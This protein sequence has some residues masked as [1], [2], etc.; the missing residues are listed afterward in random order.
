MAEQQRF[1][2]GDYWL[3]K[4]HG[5]EQWCR[6]WFDPRARQTRRTSLG[7]TDLREAQLKLAEWVTLAGAQES[8]SEVALVMKGLEALEEELLECRRLLWDRIPDAIRERLDAPFYVR[9]D[10]KS[11]RSW[12]ADF[13]RAVIEY[14]EAHAVPYKA[15]LGLRE[16]RAPC[17]LCGEVADQWYAP[18]DAPEG[19]K[20][21]RG[22][23]MHLQGDGGARK[24]AVLRQFQ[25]AR[26]AAKRE[27][28]ERL[29][30]LWAPEPPPA[31]PLVPA[32]P[33][34]ALKQRLLDLWPSKQELFVKKPF[35]EVIRSAKAHTSGKC[36]PCPLCDAKPANNTTGFTLPAG[37]KA[38]L[39]KGCP[40]FRKIEAEVR[41]RIRSRK[42]GL[43]Q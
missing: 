7:T 34:E 25:L 13:V 15:L 6:T 43:L 24:C 35:Y 20:L 10:D 37:L 9:R 11:R 41:K 19:Y 40:E 17:P 14:A 39:S 3:S 23:R 27:A 4:R 28:E 32:E 18:A 1:Q 30:S 22:L 21:P 33:G 2:I 16:V 29:G 36:A 38:H 42:S 5:S 12:H 8:E 26:L 31:V